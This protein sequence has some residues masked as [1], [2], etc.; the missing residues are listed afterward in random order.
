[1]V[2]DI[3][4]DAERRMAKSIEALQHDLAKLRTGRAH[5]S[6]LEQVM[7]PYYGN[8]TQ[9]N[10]VANISVLDA[11]TLQVVPWEKNMIGPVEKAIMTSGLGLN[12]SSVGELIRVP[13]PALTEETRRDMTRLVRQSAENA[14]VSVR[15]IRRDCNSQFK[16]LEKEKMISEDDLR[17]AEDRVQKVTDRFTKEVDV[18]IEAKEKDLMAI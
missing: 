1:M 6:L 16:D 2:E 9:L 11:R 15:N 18:H 3:I 5:P 12:P 14:R 8:D 7:V 17:R 10:Q 13:L 4:K